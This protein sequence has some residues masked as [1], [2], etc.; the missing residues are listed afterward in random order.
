MSHCSGRKQPARVWALPLLAKGHGAVKAFQTQ[1]LAPG[2][3]KSQV[4]R[5]ARYW[6]S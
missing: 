6:W 1:R 3:A 5:D 4:S 2:R